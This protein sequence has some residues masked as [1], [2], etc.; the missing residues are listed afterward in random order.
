[1]VHDGC[2]RSAVDD[3]ARPGCRV[4]DGVQA[5]GKRPLQFGAGSQEWQAPVMRVDPR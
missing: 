3:A 5:F 4:E 2:L 1:M